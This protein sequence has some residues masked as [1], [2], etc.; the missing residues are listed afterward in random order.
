MER[1]PA[2]VEAMAMKTYPIKDESGHLFAVE[3]DMV[4]IGLRNLL[5]VIASSEG[6]SG[7]AIGKG[8][9][10]GADVRATFQYHGDDYVVTEPF[11]DSSRYW[12]GPVEGNVRRDI[13]A[14]EGLL[15]DFQPSALRRIVG[16]LV[17]LDFAT[18]L[19]R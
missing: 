19:G 14:I 6:V 9:S 12:V 10:G 18:L 16:G 2:V 13:S 11:G 4:Y 17:T 7:A 8:R 5:R 15:R 3:V 1:P